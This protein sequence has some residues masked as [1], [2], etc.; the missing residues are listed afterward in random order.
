MCAGTTHYLQKMRGEQ[1]QQAKTIL[2]K[3]KNYTY[4]LVLLDEAN[5]WPYGTTLTWVN[6]FK[7]Q[8]SWK[9]GN[10]RQAERYYHESL[11]EDPWN[12][13]SIADLALLYASGKEDAAQRRS[14]AE[15]Y[16][17]KLRTQYADNPL[18]KSF[19]E[20]IEAALHIQ[21]GAAQAVRSPAAGK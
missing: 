5:R 11:A 2:E 16:L 3:T 15:P 8:A 19:L 20:K 14:R 9:L 10:T 6:Y 1:F 21:H 12:F 18:T 17:M 4:A 13:W 7:A